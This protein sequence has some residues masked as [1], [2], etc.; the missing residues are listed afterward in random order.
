M[1]R[2]FCLLALCLG[3]A[4]C[5]SDNPYTASSMPLPPAPAQVSHGPDLSAYPAPPRDYAR[6]R[7][8][9]WS[10][11]RL[12]AGTTW[13]DPAQL[14]EVVGN[15]LEQQGLRPRRDTAPP[16]LRV[17]ADLHVEKRLRQVQEDYGYA[18]GPYG[19]RYGMYPSAPIVRTYEVQVL[20]VRIS[21]FDAGTGQPIWSASAE[22]GTQGNQ[23]ERTDAL[24]DAVNK[25]LASY[26]PS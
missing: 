23:L 17:S 6:Y 12:P 19:N 26:P 4:A 14:A 20:V 8:W 3:L 11:D 1:S 24:R 5:Q 13:A 7:S 21:L 16:D 22:T 2:R 9:A 15:A 10:N 25:A 18:G